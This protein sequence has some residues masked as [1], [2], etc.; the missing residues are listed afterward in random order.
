[1]TDSQLQ[2]LLDKQALYEVVARYCRGVDR[3]DEE[4]VRSA[5]HPDAIETTVL[6]WAR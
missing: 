2:E 4:L 6:S 3:A 1:M 5:Y